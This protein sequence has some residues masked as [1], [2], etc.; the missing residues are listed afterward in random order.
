LKVKQHAHKEMRQW[1]EAWGPPTA[2]A[3]QP[4]ARR[5]PWLWVAVAVGVV[6]RGGWDPM[7]AWNRAFGD[8][9]F[10]LL[11]ITMALG[12]L[13]RLWAPAGWLLPW[14]RETGIWTHPDLGR[15]VMLQHGFGLAN[16]VGF[17]ALAYGLVLGL[18][19][20]TFSQRILGGSAWKW[21]QQGA[22]VL[23]ALVVIHTAYFLYLHFLSFHRP[24][25]P[26]NWFRVPF[27]AIV[28]LTVSLQVAAYLVT[29]LRQRSGQRPAHAHR[30]RSSGQ[31]PAERPA[32]V[33][34]QFTTCS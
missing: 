28:I 14:R 8:V 13:V 20:N 4:P 12:P 23:W 17:L 10:L 7:H 27:V 34:D 25:P 24:L 5:T 9:S 22:Y 2:V 31:T 19:S 33:H 30:G 29:W 1:L 26:E 16:A 15:Y 6:M 21:L 18:T 32:T 3:Q 11:A